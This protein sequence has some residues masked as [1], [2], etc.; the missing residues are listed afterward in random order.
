M[1]PIGTR[2]AKTTVKVVHLPSFLVNRKFLYL[3]ITACFGKIIDNLQSHKKAICRCRKCATFL[4][5]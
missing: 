1:V 5:N 3:V 2:M 4:I